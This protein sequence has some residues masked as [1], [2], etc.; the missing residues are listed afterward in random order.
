MLEHESK[1]AI[2]LKWGIKKSIKMQKSL[3]WDINGENI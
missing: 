2:Y 1:S 3:K